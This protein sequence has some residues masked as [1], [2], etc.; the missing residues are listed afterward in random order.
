MK[1]RDM[2]L[3]TK[4]M[5]GFSIILLFMA[6]VNILSYNKMATIK[7]EIDEVTTNWQGLSLFRKSTLTHPI[8]V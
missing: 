2:K 5:A 8:C 1:F 7:S 4:Q 3:G 6:V